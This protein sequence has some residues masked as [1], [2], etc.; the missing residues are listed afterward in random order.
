[1]RWPRNNLFIFFILLILSLSFLLLSRN[2]NLGKPTAVL[3]S[4]TSFF[5]RPTYGFLTWVGFKNSEV[6]KLKAQNIDL[7][8]KLVDQKKLIDDNKALNDQFLTTSIKSSTLLAANVVGAPRFIP[9]ISSPETFVID[10]GSKDG[11][12]AG[13][14]VIFKDN[15]VG[16]VTKLTENL[17][18]VTL[19]G[20]VASKFTAK[21]ENGVAGVIKGEGN[22]E[23]VL[24]NVLLSDHIQ[25]GDLVVTSGDLKIDSTGFPPELIVGRITTVD[26]NPSDLFQK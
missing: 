10:V 26:R 9:G 14:A 19:I 22:G 2:N 7:S 13:N 12:A 11:V 15:L 1:M 18:E 8:K 4:F 3:S 21:T 16:K 5:S 23:I 25:K 17:S 20:N 24:D 6:E